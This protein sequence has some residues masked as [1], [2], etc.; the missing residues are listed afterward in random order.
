MMARSTRFCSSRTLPGHVAFVRASRA[1]GEI[2]LIFFPI[3]GES[4][5][6]K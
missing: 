3:C 4:L 2:D 5:D 1:R 6:T